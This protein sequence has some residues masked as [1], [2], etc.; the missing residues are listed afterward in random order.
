MPSARKSSGF[1]LPAPPPNWL[2]KPAGL[3]LC[4]IVKNEE[5]F[6][7]RCLTSVAGIV[8]EIN[9]VDT[10]STDRT[11]EI[12]SKF[13]ANIEHREWRD[14]F[15]WARN[16]S[17]AMAGK[18]WVFQLDADEELLADSKA[19]L[20]ALKN[21]P[22]H[23][24]GL[25][26]RCSN[27]SNQYRGGTG[28]VSHLVVRL[29][30]NHER[31]RYYGAIHEFPS[32]DGSQNTLDAVAAP[33]AILHHGYLA[34]IMEGR[35]KH[36]RNLAIIEA[37]TQRNPEDAFNWYNLGVTAYLAENFERALDALLRMRSISL[38]RGMRAFVPNGLT[39]LADT[40]TDRLLRPEEGLIY[41]REAVAAAPRYCNAHFS[42]GRALEDLGR[43]DEARSLFQEAIEDGKHLE[44]HFVADEDVPVWKAQNCIA[45]TYMSEQK[46]QSALPWLL[47]AL[48]NS[49]KV[50]PARYNL[51]TVYER[52]GRL[53]EAEEML[54]ALREDFFD[55]ISCTNYVNLL[56][57]R[58]KEAEA[59]Q[60]IDADY[61]RFGA[62]TAASMLA[63]AAAVLQRNGWPGA[64]NYL[65]K[66]HELAPD[67]AEV[68]D[69][70]A[71]LHCSASQTAISRG[72]F[73]EALD[74]AQRGL[75]IAPADPALLYNAAIA[76]VNLDR[77][78]DALA[79][80][81]SVGTVHAQAYEQAEY[82]RAVLLRE[83]GN[84]ADAIEALDR[85][86]AFSGPQLDALLLRGSI[87]E[88]M[89]RGDDAEAAF[90]GA[91]PLER[92]RAAVELAS[93]YLRSGRIAE[94]QRVAE[95][96]LA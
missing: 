70:L 78:S 74:R 91:L 27:R 18:R 1:T 7:E 22:A 73:P 23:L 15:G 30:P 16:E 66:A 2:Q 63:T 75:A 9:I 3:S 92:K 86:A 19:A 4:M 72:E 32:L 25:W 93:F 45:G 5:Q 10:G 57:R 29:F 40:L 61:K 33:V 42:A 35:T 90:R 62:A 55:E 31:I 34:E 65:L 87:F 44:K 67:S 54:R 71:A 12:A 13:G 59:L 60:A 88:A 83:S 28:G 8:D 84:F 38:A 43:Y 85:M 36:A 79:Y 11:V 49:P 6:L 21:A 48:R 68:K 81:S 96:A 82:L 37:S 52:L 80:L 14:D 58:G 39:V 56:L 20:V 89:G 95:E 64:E 47:E 50:Q 24:T 51:A 46:F 76:C 17:L 41:A 77:K 53:D 69:L 94:A 26:V